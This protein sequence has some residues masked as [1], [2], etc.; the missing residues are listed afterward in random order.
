[1][2]HGMGHP[3][4]SMMAG[5][6]VN[7]VITQMQDDLA[8]VGVNHEMGGSLVAEH[9]LARSRE[10]IGIID[11]GPHALLVLIKL[12]DYSSSLLAEGATS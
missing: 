5:L 4:S 1:M 7:Y 11:N 10:T 8:C 12:I 2:L 3:E 9:F 6:P